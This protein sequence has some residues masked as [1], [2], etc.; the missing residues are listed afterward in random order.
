[1]VSGV[2]KFLVV[3]L[4]LAVNLGLVGAFGGAEVL[5][6]DI[7]VHVPSRMFAFPASRFDASN[8]GILALAHPATRRKSLEA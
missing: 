7:L 4:E 1:M 8:T 3:V 5:G 6:S 2:V